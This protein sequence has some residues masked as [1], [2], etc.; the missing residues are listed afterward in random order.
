MRRSFLLSV[1][2]LVGTTIGAGVFALPSL[3]ARMGIWQTSLCF[4]ALALLIATTYVL[5]VDVIVSESAA[6]RLPGYVRLKLGKHWGAFATFTHYFHIY[7]AHVIYLLLGG[8]FFQALL[9]TMGVAVPT[10]AGLILLFLLIGAAVWG[11]LRKVARIELVTTGIMLV[12][13]AMVITHSLTQGAPATVFIPQPSWSAFGLI[14]FALTGLPAI[15]E[16]VELS[17]RKQKEA[18]RAVLAGT[19][20]AALVIWLFAMALARIGGTQITRDPQS[21]AAVLDGWGPIVIPMVGIF[22]VGTAYLC[23]AEDLQSSWIHD[24]KLSFRSAWIAA[25]V[26]SFLIAFILG[27]GYVILASLLGTVCGGLN[28]VFVGMMRAGVAEHHR[29]RSLLIL[30]LVIVFIYAFGMSGQ[31]ASWLLL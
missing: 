27:D 13:F 30:S 4:W 26:P 7:G 12:L 24:H 21:L 17:G 3:F 1:C 8:V 31:I 5:Y 2:T 28:G 9:A 19:F 29:Q 15:G 10:R 20:L 23:T 11:G 22:S 14:L 16:I 25:I 6:H 18:H